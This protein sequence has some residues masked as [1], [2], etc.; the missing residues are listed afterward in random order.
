MRPHW[1]WPAAL[2]ALFLFA[3][4]GQLAVGLAVRDSNRQNLEA[5]VEAAKESCQPA[6]ISVER[7]PKR[8][9]ITNPT[10][11]TVFVSFVEPATTGRG[12]KIATHEIFDTAVA[13]D[14]ELHL[15][16]SCPPIRNP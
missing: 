15:L 3:T 12:W 16:V 11:C 8:T 13:Q 4:G 10:S 7:G 9:R 6:G 14:V 1:H 5:A 2:V